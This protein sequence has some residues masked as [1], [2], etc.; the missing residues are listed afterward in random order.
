MTKKK[1][2]KIPNLRKET[3]I[4]VYTK[5]VPRKINQKTN[6]R[7]HTVIKMAKV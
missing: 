1:K 2:K 5:K 4:Q 3:D 6:T 7:R